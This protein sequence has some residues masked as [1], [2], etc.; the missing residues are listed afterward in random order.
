MHF[1]F[2]YLDGVSNPAVDGFDKTTFPGQDSIAPGN[3]LTGVDGDA[4]ERPP[5]AKE[6][7]LCRKQYWEST[8]KRAKSKAWMDVFVVIQKGELS[9]FIFGDHSLGSANVVGGGNWLVSHIH[10]SGVSLV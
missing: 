1:S 5:W 8:G 10:P 2:G 7:M 6:G 3:I 9:M 4:L